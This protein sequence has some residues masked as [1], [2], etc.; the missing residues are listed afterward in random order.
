ML[1]HVHRRGNLS[2]AAGV[3][4]Q[5]EEMVVKMLGEAGEELAAAAQLDDSWKVQLMEGWRT[6]MDRGGHGWNAGGL[7]T[8]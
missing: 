5:E 2:D 3:V 8:P 7:E 4:G 6:L 1:H